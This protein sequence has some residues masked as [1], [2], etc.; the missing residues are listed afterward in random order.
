MKFEELK[1]PAHCFQEIEMVDEKEQ[2]RIWPLLK[3][4]SSSADYSFP[5]LA[6]KQEKYCKQVKR[7]A[8]SRSF[9]R[10]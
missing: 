6:L 7:L 1:L 5:K 9:E 8:H 4:F 2:V 3:K 10:H